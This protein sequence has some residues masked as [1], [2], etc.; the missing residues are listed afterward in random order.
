MSRASSCNSAAGSAAGASAAPA[1]PGAAAAL[2]PGLRPVGTSPTFTAATVPPAL[3]QRHAT[4]AGCWAQL[5][6][7]SGALLYTDLAV[8]TEQRVAA[9]QQVV[10][11]PTIP[12]RV[13]VDESAPE[14]VA[15]RLEFHKA[16]T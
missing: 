16:A 4:A 10:I 6:V 7:S 15:F 14:P 1:A 8:G 5:I 9:G 13:S 12:H 3:L 11:P 2:P